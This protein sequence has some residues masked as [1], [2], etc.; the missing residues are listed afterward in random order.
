MALRSKSPRDAVPTAA[1]TA[2]AR[3]WLL[4]VHMLP[5][6]PTG[7][8]VRT[9][10]RLQQIGA[11]AVKQSVYVLPDSPGAREDF[12]WLKTEIDAGG[13][14][15]TVIAADTVD[16]WSN[17]ALIEEFREARQAGY[18]ELARHI[19]RVVARGSRAKKQ[20]PPA[21]RLVDGF[22]Q[23]LLALEQVDFFGSAG[24]D[25]VVALLERLERT[26]AGVASAG[27][28]AGHGEANPKSYRQRVWV[29]RPRPG[30]DRMAS[31]WLIRRFIDREARFDFVS[32]V[33]QAPA[34]AVT[35]DMFGGAFT[36]RGGHCT[37]E[38]LADVF[39][40]G[41][42]S[43]KRLAAIVHDL[44]LKDGRFASPEASTIG[45][46]ITGLQLSHE[47]DQP[48]LEQ[49]ITL[50]ESLYRA[51]ASADRPMRPRPVSST[52]GRRRAPRAAGAG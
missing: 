12:E 52:R 7:V 31:A 49:G 3:R 24:R 25:R 6:T 36:H 43:V 11:I 23:R 28:A 2:A 16:A 45:A 26:S 17:D 39:G 48:L 18:A 40:L 22:R 41:D 33:K 13:V 34:D 44:D 37:Y 20:I 42:P 38:V 47:D 30:V 27:V 15:A 51:F 35:F 29:T 1:V 46:V 9:W 32:D 8:R 19:E 5:A 14:E 50:F 4:L 10:R 21:T